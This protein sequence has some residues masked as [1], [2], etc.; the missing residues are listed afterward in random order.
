VTVQNPT[1]LKTVV[2][3]SDGTQVNLTEDLN[4]NGVIDAG[5]PDYEAYAGLLV[6]NNAEFLYEST[7]FWHFGAVAQ[8]VLGVKPCY[9]DPRWA[10]AF[11]VE[12]QGVTQELFNQLLTAAGFANFDALVTEFATLESCKNKKEKKGGCKDRYKE[13]SGL[14]DLGLVVTGQ[15]GGGGGGGGTPP[16]GL[17]SI[18]G[19]PVVIEGGVAEGG[20]TSGPN[21]ETGRRTWIDITPQ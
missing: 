17:E 13:L 18:T 4:A 5:A 12:T 10:E 6:S 19:S 15:V 2:V 3:L 1:D 21:F 20:V 7:L 14:Y 8:L 11:I 9:G 16:T